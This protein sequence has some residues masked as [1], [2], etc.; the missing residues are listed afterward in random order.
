MSDLT[1]YIYKTTDY[2][3]TWQLITD[4][5]RGDDFVYVVREDPV[6]PGLL[7]AGSEKGVYVSFDDGASW[8]SLQRNLPVVAVM[9]MRVKGNDLVAR[10]ARP[11]GVDHG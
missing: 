5:I 11:R 1:P 2:G 4:G 8:Q 3:Q 10:D 6:R 9:S 7:Y